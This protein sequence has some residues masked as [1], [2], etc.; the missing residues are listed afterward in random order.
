MANYKYENGNYYRQSTNGTWFKVSRNNDGYLTWTQSDGKQ[1]YDNTF[2]VPVMMQVS[3]GPAGQVYT[4]GT[5]ANGSVGRYFSFQDAVNSYTKAIDRGA[6]SDPSENIG[7]DLMFDV[8]TGKGAVSLTTKGVQAATKV[9]PKA[10]KAAW[11]MGKRL[12]TGQVTKQSVKQGAKKAGAKIAEAAIREVP[13]TTA[14]VLAGKAVNQASES[15][16][17]KSWGENIANGLTNHWGF[18]VSPEV[19]EFTNPGYLLGYKWMDRGIRR[20]S[21]NNITPLSYDD[22]RVAPLTKFQEGVEIIKD[23]PKQ[24]FS[25]KEIE[26]PAWRTRIESKLAALDWHNRYNP[27][28]RDLMKS[29]N[30]K[31]LLDNREDALRLAFGFTPRTSLYIR[32]PDGT[33]RYN[34]DYVYKTNPN[35]GLVKV[36]E[37]YQ[38][39]PQQFDYT[40]K[41]KPYK[42]YADNLA[43][44][45]GGIGYKEKDGV[46]YITDT[47]D[48]QP[49]KDS[50]RLPSF[51]G[52]QFMHK[53]LPDLEVF[54]ALGGK[55]F[56]L[57]M[58][59]PTYVDPYTSF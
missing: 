56:T 24:L 7:N 52:A 25:L 48:V 55:P 47:W 50:F 28:G 30:N 46:S 51:K 8:A 21:F 59:I 9:V 29:I 45:G 6:F 13:R 14:A 53:Y 19:G 58:S 57:K 11:N 40:S 31:T 41:G 49:F 1:V 2:K 5:G 43:K 4:V 42:G 26:S 54:N 37:G 20:A 10:A 35:S 38:Y 17:G 36:P 18:Q 23:I 22:Y 39:K 27:N 15:V 33:Y 44:N 34:L 12:V 16:T 3:K 32:N